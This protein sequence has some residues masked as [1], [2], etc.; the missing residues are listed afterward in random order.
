MKVAA[1]RVVV[2]MEVAARVVAVAVEVAVEVAVAVEVTRACQIVSGD[3]T[4]EISNA[5]AEWP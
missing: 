2:A 4:V 5:V 3:E 1:E